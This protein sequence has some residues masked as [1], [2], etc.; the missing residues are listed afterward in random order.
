MDIATPSP[1]FAPF[2]YFKTFGNY[3]GDNEIIDSQVL[4]AN[5][6]L[7]DNTQADQKPG[8]LSRPGADDLKETALFGCICIV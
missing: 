3:E 8:L 1:A 2:D 4:F 5:Q 7:I 6:G